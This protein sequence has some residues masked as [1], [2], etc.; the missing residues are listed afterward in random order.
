MTTK[1]ILWTC[2]YCNRAC[3]LQDSD[4]KFLTNTV[5]LADDHGSVCGNIM[6]KICPNPECRKISVEA[7]IWDYNY[8]TQ[9]TGKLLYEW[10]LVPESNAKPFPDYV[11]QPLRDDYQEACL[12]KYKSAKAS[13]TLCRRCL[14]GIIRDFW[15]IKKAKL[16]DEITELEGKVD[17]KTWQAID[18]VRHVGNIGA[19]MEKDVNLIIDVDPEE[20]GLLIWLIETLFEEWY[21]ERHEKDVKMQKIIEVAKEKTLQKNQPGSTKK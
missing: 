12:I 11:P 19:H 1:A 10:F 20:A 9:K 5:H 8:G 6:F 14:Q 4:I 21:I 18:S 2:P 15:G 7:R 17:A 13:A 3:T 16:I